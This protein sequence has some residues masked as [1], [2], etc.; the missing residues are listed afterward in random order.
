MGIGAS[1][2]VES[3]A[4]AAAVRS[5]GERLHGIAGTNHHVVSPLGAWLLL[6]LCAPLARDRECDNLTDALAADPQDAAAFAR[7]LLSA[8]HPVVAGAAGVWVRHNLVTPGVAGWIAALPEAV[9]TGDIPAQAHLDAWASEKTSGLIAR[10]PGQITPDLT[11][12]LASA[13]ATKITWD[14]PFEVVDST[15]LGQ[16][17][18]SR[19]VRTVLRAHPRHHNYLTVTRRA[20]TVGVHLAGA[21]AG[22][23]VASVIAERDVAPGDVLA[24]AQEI[25]CCEARRRGSVSGLSLF[26]LPLGQGPAWT[27]DEA[28]VQTVSPNRREETISSVMPAWTADTQLDLAADPLGFPAAARALGRALDNVD[29]S[30]RARHSATARFSALGFEAAAVTGIGAMAIPGRLRRTRQRYATIRFAHPYAVVAAVAEGDSGAGGPAPDP[31]RGL[32]VF[33]AWISKPAE[34]EPST[35][36]AQEGAT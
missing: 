10:F 5:Y 21:R 18:W 8:P 13:L 9:D 26:K 35:G 31:W 32:P 15:A 4:W 27:V 17:P 2:S 34:A 25:V 29:T 20:G 3:D 11:F 16:G 22:L 6:A 1:V 14:D 24:A 19:Q 33:S 28:R 7:L 36:L 30:Y 23:L 12:L